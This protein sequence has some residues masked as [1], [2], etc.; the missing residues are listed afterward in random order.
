MSGVPMYMNTHTGMGAPQ[1]MAT[2]KYTPFVP[3]ASRKYQTADPLGGT[4]YYPAAYTPY[5]NPVVTYN[6]PWMYAQGQQQLPQHMQQVMPAQ[7]PTHHHHLH[8]G[9]HD[10]VEGGGDG[11]DDSA[12]QP[13]GGGSAQLANSF[14][15][16]SL[17]EGGHMGWDGRNV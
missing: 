12:G 17:E 16:M 15:T 14:A 6:Q 5:Y 10:S 11:G 3:A 8:A 1:A 9:G 4:S 2:Q 7:H 13:A